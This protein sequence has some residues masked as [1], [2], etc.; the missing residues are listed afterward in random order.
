MIIILMLTFDLPSVIM[1]FS[2][3]YFRKIWKTD[4][5]LKL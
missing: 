1:V 4:A 5:T 2:K 3:N